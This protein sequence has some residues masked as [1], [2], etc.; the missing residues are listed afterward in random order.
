MRTVPL[1]LVVV[2]FGFVGNAS[3]QSVYGDGD[4]D[5]GPYADS[6]LFQEQTPAPPPAPQGPYYRLDQGQAAPVPAEPQQWKYNGPH[7][8]NADYGEGWCNLRG[9]HYHE[10]PPFDDHLF[11]EDQGG[12]DFLGDPVD[13]GYTGGD[14]YWYNSAHPIAAGW[15]TGWCYIPYAHRHLYAPWGPYFATCGDDYSCYYGPFDAA[16]WYY[17]PYW[18]GFWGRSYPYFYG[19]GHYYRTGVAASPGRWG[20]YRP[21]AGAG[22][23]GV[24]GRGAGVP[25]GRAGGYAHPVRPMP[26]LST[27]VTLRGRIGSGPGMAMPR[28]APN[29]FPRTYAGPRQAPMPRT[30]TVPRQGAPRFGGGSYA[31]P[32]FGGGSAPRFGGSAPRFGG[33]SAPRFNAPHPSAP[34]PSFSAPRPSGGGFH[35]GRR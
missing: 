18:L 7:A 4:L 9:P 6:P 11:Q 13:F 32:R 12:Y 3:A 21:G 26:K 23:Y 5:D 1:A 17:R 16:Y 22:R 30:Y 34:R 24:P 14:T 2:L 33:G 27:P 35:G 8:V 19:H 20:H 31:A 10:Y 25:A 29:A 15:G 28:V